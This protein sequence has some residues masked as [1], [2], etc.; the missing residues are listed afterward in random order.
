MR[1]IVALSLIT[2]VLVLV[3]ASLIQ[4]EPV[5]FGVAVRAW[6]TADVPATPLFK[7][8]KTLGA[9]FCRVLVPWS[10][11]QPTPDTYDWASLDLMVAQAAEAGIQLVPV[12]AAAP[13]WALPLKDASLPFAEFMREA[14]TRYKGQIAYWQV[15]TNENLGVYWD[16]EP[17]PTSYAKLLRAGYLA[18]HRGDSAASVVLGSPWGADNAY[19][20]GLYEAGA[21]PYFD[22]AS[23][24]LFTYPNAPEADLPDSPA[25]PGQL[26]TFRDVMTAQGDEAKP[27]WVTSLGWPT[28]EVATL[29]RLS[30][31]LPPMLPLALAELVAE[32]HVQQVAVFHEPELPG[33]EDR[34]LEYVTR[35]VQKSGLRCK[36][37]DTTELTLAAP[38]DYA[39]W[40]FP[41]GQVFPA[42]LKEP[43]LAFLRSGGLVVC[44]FDRP[45]AKLA[46]KAKKGDWVITPNDQLAE[47]EALLRYQTRTAPEGEGLITA[48][49]DPELG[50][51]LPDPHLASPWVVQPG[52]LGSGDMFIP[53]L[54]S[55]RDGQSLG[56]QAAFIRYDSDLKGGLALLLTQVAG[57]GVS[58]E[59]QADYLQR[60]LTLA[61]AKGA[62]GAF[63]YEL[64]E[65]LVA[66]EAE[67]LHF[68][69]LRADGS[70]KPAYG[71]YQV[72]SKALTGRHF[73]GAV[74][75]AK[76][77]FGYNFA[78]EDDRDVTSVLWTNGPPTAITVNVSG[79]QV[80]VLDERLRPR[81]FYRQGDKLTFT[82][83]GKVTFLVSAKKVN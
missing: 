44:A 12:V 39:A 61:F 79:R 30:A 68:G 71:A 8:A 18:A 75:L 43:L 25:M 47:W 20:T 23:L 51:Q 41:Q 19:L 5:R 76:G 42:V 52:Q 70:R 67:T 73:I 54:W 38:T 82:A 14:T 45:F 40:I 36:V 77:V 22:I 1:K 27:L 63:W 16:G 49:T 50:L 60:A 46:V 3:I 17:N 29:E 53:L 9:E 69:L 35:W 59:L 33:S 66:G 57:G 4:A 37:V 7:E 56:I 2:L 26:A 65:P 31:I 34:R 6:P 64:Q 32:P 74:E 78:T 55:K 24:N 80:D 62:T 28:S 48:E 11:V 83:N 21:G 72:M 10:L 15:W 81:E 58:E 13:A